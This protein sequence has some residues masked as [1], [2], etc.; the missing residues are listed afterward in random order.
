MADTQRSATELLGADGLLEVGGFRTVSVQ[1][2]RDFCV[3]APLRDG[4]QGFTAVV[5]GVTPTADDHLATKGYVDA[6]PKL[7]SI[8]MDVFATT[9]LTRNVWSE[10]AGTFA[11]GSPGSSEWTLAPS[12]AGLVWGGSESVWVDVVAQCAFADAG[13]GNAVALGVAVEGTVQGDHGHTL[14]TSLGDTPGMVTQVVLV[15]PGETVSLQIQNHTSD[16]DA[17]IIHLTCTMRAH[18]P[19]S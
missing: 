9:A 4:T 3:S 2:V 19:Q 10:I 7:G 16:D 6:W 1:D 11:L 14:T 5:E 8:N 12:G 17:D 18:L 15:A 13:N